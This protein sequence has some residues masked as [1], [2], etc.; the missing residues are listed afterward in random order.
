MSLFFHRF[1]SQVTIILSL[2]VSGISVTSHGAALEEKPICHNTQLLNQGYPSATEAIQHACLGDHLVLRAYTIGSSPSTE[3]QSVGSYCSRLSGSTHLPQF[4]CTWTQE[5]DRPKLYWV[6]VQAIIIVGEYVGGKVV[7]KTSAGRMLDAAIDNL[8]GIEVES[9]RASLSRDVRRIRV[10]FERMQEIF[11]NERLNSRQQR[12]QIRK[13]ISDLGLRIDTMEQQ[14]KQLNRRIYELEVQQQRQL[15][16]I[17][18]NEGRIVRLENEILGLNGRIQSVE[19]RVSAV[20]R[21][22][23]RTDRRVQNLEDR[24]FFERA[25]LYVSGGINYISSMN[26]TSGQHVGLDFSLQFNPNN[27]VGVIIGYDYSPM[28]APDASRFTDP[29]GNEFALNPGAAVSWQT[30][31][32]YA[33]FNV[34]LLPPY[35]PISLQ[36]GANG[37][38]LIGTLEGHTNRDIFFP[39]G[40]ASFDKVT[41]PAGALRAEFAFGKP[42]WFIV[43]YF[44]GS[45]RVL[46]QE[47][48]DQQ[49]SNAG[50]HFWGGSIGLRIRFTEE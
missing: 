5:K 24:V 41:T 16:R 49:L 20:E 21:R 42:I 1:I 48:S 32:A 40:A 3:P 18:D 27:H 31:Y 13:S 25:P 30:H 29:Q 37:G 26:F 50:K 36:A 7:D 11:D 8:F 35:S 47:L 17:V 6:V 28:E 10:A 34:E 23:D 19:G 14:I 9:T 39:T 43:P 12:Q 38:L 4:N 15:R 44:S 33:G 22:Q 46:Y 2:L 45:Y